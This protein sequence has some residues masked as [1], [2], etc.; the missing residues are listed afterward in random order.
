MKREVMRDPELMALFGLLIGVTVSI[1]F[2]AIEFWSELIG[3]EGVAWSITIELV[4][5]F[6]WFC[7]GRGSENKVLIQTVAIGATIIALSG[8][9][10]KNLVP[11]VESISKVNNLLSTYDNRLLE[12]V[13]MIEDNRSNLSMARDNSKSRMGWKDTIDRSEANINR[14]TREKEL[15]LL[16]KPSVSEI[17]TNSVKGILITLTLIIFQLASVLI[18]RNISAKIKESNSENTRNTQKCALVS[19][20]SNKSQNEP[21]VDPESEIALHLV[22]KAAEKETSSSVIETIDNQLTNQQKEQKII[23]LSEFMVKYKDDHSYA[24][25]REFAKAGKV[26]EK[27]LAQ[28]LNHKVNLLKRESNPNI[29]IITYEKA[30]ILGVT[31]GFTV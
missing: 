28:L 31:F 22:R 30:A 4:A 18:T 3:P 2:H 5:I 29:R 11:I 17:I 14:L 13:K 19:G 16:N 6:A 20:E 10:V 24:T 7:T 15:M 9:A 23:E 8:P 1:Q 12:K 21:V 26:N 27:N 25:I